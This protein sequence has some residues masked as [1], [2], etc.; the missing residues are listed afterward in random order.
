MKGKSAVS[1]LDHTDW[2][3]LQKQAEGEINCSD[4]P[5]TDENFWADA[6]IVI[7]ERKVHLSIRLDEDIVE[8]FKQFGRGYQTR[9]NAVLRS[10]I[11]HVIR[12]T[13]YHSHSG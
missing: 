6:E 11:Q 5:E 8:W 2:V 4:I 7:P 12:K 1:E 13:K 9:I 3:R 10:Y